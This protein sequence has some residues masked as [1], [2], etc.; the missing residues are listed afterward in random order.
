M[1]YKNE[2]DMFALLLR[3]ADSV[4]LSG[5]GHALCDADNRIRYNKAVDSLS[6]GY[7]EDFLALRGGK[8]HNPS[9]GQL[10]DRLASHFDDQRMQ[11]KGGPAPK[12]DAYENHYELFAFLTNCVEAYPHLR[13][14]SK[15]NDYCLNRACLFDA[16]DALAPADLKIFIKLRGRIVKAGSD[17][18]MWAIAGYYDECRAC[19]EA[20]KKQEAARQAGIE[21]AARRRSLF[22]DLRKTGEQLDAGPKPSIIL[23]SHHYIPQLDQRNTTMFKQY[24][25]TPTLLNGRNIEQ[26]N[27][28]DLFTAVRDLE[29]DRRELEKM[30]TEAKAVTKQIAVIDAAIKVVVKHLDAK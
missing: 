15:S 18:L 27:K 20:N 30:T 28:D 29:E 8:I 9:T 24:I 23:N 22:E 13:K 25:E 2:D 14:L 21:I 5:M 26:F 12:G 7:K 3:A 1:A 4:T 6:H 17:E 19:E 10:I 16:L 11:E